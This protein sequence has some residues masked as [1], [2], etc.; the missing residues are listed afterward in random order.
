MSL[1]PT[2][3]RYVPKETARVAKAAFPKGTLGLYLR[4]ELAGLYSDELFAD[5]Y[6]SCT[7]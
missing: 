5:L 6:A 2:D 3:L 1:Q 4:D 7:C